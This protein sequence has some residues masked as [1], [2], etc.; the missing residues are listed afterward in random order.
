MAFRP[1]SPFELLNGRL[2]C[3]PHRRGVCEICGVDY[4]Y[5]YE[6]EDEDQ[7]ELTDES[8]YEVGPE[9]V[10]HGLRG[11]GPRPSDRSPAESGSRSVPIAFVGHHIFEPSS[12]GPN[13]ARTG[14]SSYCL[15]GSH[16]HER[17]PF[18]LRTIFTGRVLPEKFVPPK[19][20]D[21]P[22]ILFPLSGARPSPLGPSLRARF[23][24][25]NNESQFLIYADGSCSDN[26]APNARAGC[27]FIFK[28]CSQ[29]PSAGRVR[30]ALENK[31]PT[32]ERH[33]HTSNRAELRAVI[34]ALRYRR[35]SGEG[36]NSLVIATDSEYVANG[37][38]QWIQA[39]LRNGWKTSSGATVKNQDLW[40]CLLNEIEEHHTEGL[41]VQFWRIP[42]EWNEV[43][44]RY[45]REAANETPS[46]TW[47][48][49]FGVLT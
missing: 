22:Q 13:L 42:R 43:A 49:I 16:S 21:R 45:A 10:R 5:M 34:A 8:D 40:K 11:L 41:R 26:G 31:G 39:W 36:F 48:D 38:T 44:D 4:D 1:D 33:Q 46:E 23:V 9:N 37:A 15:P 28:N 7:Y 3:G 18:G 19:P 24:R 35:W 47:N 2:V 20:T 27:A 17:N 12:P 14:L 29:N 30:F 32:G 25:A 6:D